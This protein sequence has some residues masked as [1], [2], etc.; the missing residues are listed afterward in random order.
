MGIK[1]H[2]VVLILSVFEIKK[3]GCNCRLKKNICN[4]CREI[5]LFKQRKI[6]NRHSI[7]IFIF[8]KNYRLL[9]FDLIFPF[10]FSNGSRSQLVVYSF[11]FLVY[12]SL[13]LFLVCLYV[14]VKVCLK[15]N[16]L[17]TVAT[18]A[19]SSA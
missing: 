7:E 3:F 5:G 13:S 10:L 12:C 17:T 2:V 11:F 14:M 19:I 16:I 15:A 18:I 8:Q 9:R 6:T 4:F 1:F